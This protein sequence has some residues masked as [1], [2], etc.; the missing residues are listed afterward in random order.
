MTKLRLLQILSNLTSN[1]LKFTSNGQIDIKIT[2][3]EVWNENYEIK[4]EIIDS[5]IGISPEN[6]EKLF[7]SFQQL[8]ISTKKQ[9][10]GTGLGL[11]ISKELSRQMG[12]EIGLISKQGE[13][14]NFWFTITSKKTNP[15]QVISHEKVHEEITLLNYFKDFSP[16]ILLV[17]DNSVNRKVASEILKKA[18]CEI[19]SAESGMEAIEIYQEIQDFDMI[20]MD[21]QMPEMDGIETTQRL[22]KEFGDTL[23]TVVAMTAYSMQND[24]ENF[25]SKGLDDYVSKPIRA[26]ILIK[27]VEEIYLGKNNRDIKKGRRKRSD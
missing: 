4:F 21:I 23:P 25:L 1:A 3:K 10:G 8:D 5:G 20:L 14:S 11:V 15:E 12:G 26:N 7:N 24:R 16:K 17:D 22:K 27:K 2:A 18:N 13:G 6:Q 19:I 9:F